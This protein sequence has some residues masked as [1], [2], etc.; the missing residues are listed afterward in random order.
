M[1]RPSPH[2]S[3]CAGF[4]LIE[5]LAV[6]VIIS[7]LAALIFPTFKNMTEN[8]YR[9][10]CINNL[11]SIFVAANAAAQDNNNTYPLIQ[12]NANKPYFPATSGAKTMLQAF[13]PYGLSVKSLQCP[14][15]MERGAKSDFALY[16]SSYF[17]YP[18]S[19]DSTDVAITVYTRRGAYPRKL[20]KVQ[21][22]ADW[23][24]IHLVYLPAQPAN[25]LTP[26]VQAG[27]I[28]RFNI[29]YADGHILPATAQVPPH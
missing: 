24:G 18:Y 25:G 8:A 7:L 13:Q 17:W 14:T 28:G 4:T 20:S 29:V 11:K 1:I 21:M 16:Q 19:E 22:A 26:A 27:F 10:T 5:L 9:T 23:E 6:I 2:S 15:D 3:R 12:F